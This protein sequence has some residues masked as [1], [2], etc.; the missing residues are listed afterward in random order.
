MCRGVCQCNVDPTLFLQSVV[1]KVLPQ[2]ESIPSERRIALVRSIALS[3]SSLDSKTAKS[4]LT[5]VWDWCK[6][7]LPL[8]PSTE[9]VKVD[10]SSHLH[11]SLVESLLALVHSLA[12]TSPEGAR[13]VLGLF[14]STGQPA[15][16]RVEAVKKDSLTRLTQLQTTAQQWGT[17]IPAVLAEARKALKEEKEAEAKKPLQKRAGQLDAG[18]KIADSIVQLTKALTGKTP[19]FSAEPTVSWRRRGREGKGGEGRKT[20]GSHNR[21]E[22]RRREEQRERAKESSREL[23]KSRG[24]GRAPRPLLPPLQSPKGLGPPLPRLPP[25]RRTSEGGISR[26]PSLTPPLPQRAAVGRAQS[27]RSRS[28]GGTRSASRMQRTS[29]PPHLSSRRETPTPSHSREEEEEEEGGG[30]AVVLRSGRPSRAVV[31]VR[32]GVSRGCLRCLPLPS[33]LSRL[34]LLRRPTSLRCS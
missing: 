33:P 14:L 12:A 27:A 6:S 32:V 25:L 28:R 13:D 24:Q 11:F 19:M 16:V 26:W 31:S 23:V 17:L 7:L 21:A 22:R 5:S 10:D 20:R 3:A 8:S 4:L 30:E 15:D 2:V 34:R 18:K 9:E 29:P 1:S